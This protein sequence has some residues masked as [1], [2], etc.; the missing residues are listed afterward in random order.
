ML[1][2]LPYRQFD[3]MLTA[4]Y[5]AIH[6]LGRFALEKLRQDNR[7]K[8][9]GCWT[10]TNLYSA[11]MLI[12]AFGIWWFRSSFAV[13]PIDTRIE[14][15]SVVANPNVLCWVVPFSV[16]FFFSHGVQYK[17]VGLWLCSSTVSEPPHE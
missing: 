15:H 1:Q 13:T 7:G 10:H 3:G 5:F 17:K 11:L 9:W 6:P 8:L 14:W 4:V 2:L 16:I 12:G